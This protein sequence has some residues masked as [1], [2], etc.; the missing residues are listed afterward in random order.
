MPG[1]SKRDELLIA[2]L[3]LAV[4]FALASVALEE[5]GTSVGA[6]LGLT[7]GLVGLYGAYWV[8]RGVRN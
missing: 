1:M 5:R 7:A 2:T 4:C 3:L 8:V 6:A